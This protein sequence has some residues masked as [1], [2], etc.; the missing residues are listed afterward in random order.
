MPVTVPLSA[1]KT[2]RVDEE[3]VDEEG[4]AGV[5]VPI[6]AQYMARWGARAACLLRGACTSPAIRR[7]FCNCATTVGATIIPHRRS[8]GRGRRAARIAGEASL[9]LAERSPTV[10]RHGDMPTRRVGICPTLRQSK[11]CCARHHPYAV[12]C[13]ALLL[14]SP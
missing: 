3:R 4:G 1:G 11:T 2:E 14:R 13:F 7:P 12:K 6:P 9:A 5:G 8:G 10:G